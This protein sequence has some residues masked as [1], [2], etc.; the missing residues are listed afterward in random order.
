MHSIG[1]APTID[2]EQHRVGRR[3]RLRRALACLPSSSS[4]PSSRPSPG[5]GSCSGTSP[6]SR[7]GACSGAGAGAGA[8]PC[9][10]AGAL[11]AGV[12]G[13][14]AGVDAGSLNRGTSGSGPAARRTGSVARGLLLPVRRLR[15]R[16]LRPRTVGAR[17]AGSAVSAVSSAAVPAAAIA[18]GRICTAA[19][20]RRNQT[21]LLLDLCLKVIHR[22]QHR[23]RDVLDLLGR[24]RHRRRLRIRQ[25]RRGVGVPLPAVISLH[26]IADHGPI[27]Q[28]QRNAAG[29]FIPRRVL[30]GGP[31]DD[32]DIA[33]LRIVDRKD[34]RSADPD[35]RHRRLEHHVVGAGFGDT[36]G[37]EFGRAGNKA[38]RAFP[39]RLR[40]VV[41]QLIENQFAVFPQGQRGAI[42]KH[43]AHL[44]AF[45]GLDDVVLIE[46]IADL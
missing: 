38:Q 39:C 35:G 15:S 25:S 19:L 40:R 29:G 30:A 7:A 6:C 26:R 44:G 45:V 2:T 18:P 43:Q 9:S 32:G 22:V 3:R 37:D 11:T 4:R 42:D 5:A 34:A 10:R 17:A 12:P 31:V 16:V 27:G 8:G 13:N 21:R 24:E 36:A 20:G 1:R 28:D 46:R 41:H 23:A 33:G 14:V